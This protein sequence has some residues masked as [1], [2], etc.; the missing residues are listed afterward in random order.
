MPGSTRIASLC[1]PGVPIIEAI[2]F[3]AKRKTPVFGRGWHL[4]RD[5]GV[6]RPVAW[7]NVLYMM[8]MEHGPDRIPA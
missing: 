8:G 3:N 5:E 1:G 2:L 7:E 4:R 6:G